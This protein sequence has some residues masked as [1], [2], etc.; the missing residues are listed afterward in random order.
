MTRVFLSSPIKKVLN[1]GKSVVTCFSTIVMTYIG[2]I[3]RWVLNYPLWMVRRRMS[4][5]RLGNRSNS[6][7]RWQEGPTYC[8]YVPPT[9]L[10]CLYNVSFLRHRCLSTSF[11]HWYSHYSQLANTPSVVHPPAISL[12]LQFRSPFFFLSAEGGTGWFSRLL[13]SRRRQQ[14]C[15]EQRLPVALHFQF[16]L[17]AMPRTWPPIKGERNKAS[18]EQRV[19]KRGVIEFYDDPSCI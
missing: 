15:H 12:F 18:E 5:R 14:S 2:A 7:F 11:A 10:E 8:P 6:S 17:Y 3:K 9:C 19:S 1:G 4:R 16:P 13:L